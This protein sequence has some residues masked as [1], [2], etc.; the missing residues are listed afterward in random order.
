MNIIKNFRRSSSILVIHLS[1]IKSLFPAEINDITN[2]DSILY[3]LA[4]ITVTAT[5]FPIKQQNV[6]FALTPID[7]ISLQTAR[8]QL[9]LKETLASVPGLLALNENNFSQDLR[10]SIRGFGARASFGIRGI[11]VLIDG[12]PE[13]TPDGQTQ[14]DNLNLGVIDR[15]EVVR[16]PTSALYGNA[17]GGVINIS[18]QKP[19][20]SLLLNTKLTGGSYDFRNIQLK[21][22]QDFGR[23]NILLSAVHS[24]INGYRAHSA[25]KTYIING[26]LQVKPD[27]IS[28]LTL[29]LSWEDSPHADDPG[30]LTREQMTEDPT[31]ASSNNLKFN[32]GEEVNQGKVGLFYKRMF[33]PQHEIQANAYFTDRNF[34]NRLPFEQGG[35]VNLGRDY[36]GVNF[37]YLHTSNIL[38]YSSQFAAGLEFADQR[39]DRKR[40]NN[41]NGNRGDLVLNQEERYTNSAL[42]AQEEIHFTQRWHLNLG[43]RYDIV[44]VRVKNLLFENGIDS[45]ERTLKGLS[46]MIGTLFRMTDNHNLYGNISSGFE[47]P[48][49]IELTN[50][51]EGDSGLN[52]TLNAQQA[53]NYEIGL[54]GILAGKFRYEMALFLIDVYD[55]LL[56]YE[57]AE[58]PGRFYYRNAGRSTHK[59]FELGINGYLTTGLTFALSY[60]LSRFHFVDY[61]LAENNFSDN[62]IPG[63]PEHMWYTEFFYLS[64]SG[65]YSRLEIQGRSNMYVNDAN[66]AIDD[67]YSTV[68]IQAGYRIRFN[69]WYI[70]PFFGI[71]NIF[72]VSYSDNVRINAFGE[73]YYEPAPEFNIFVGLNIHIGE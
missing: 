11:K 42:F 71:N 58:S 51:P 40:F 41:I 34:S 1:I 69:R 22:G 63:I 8:R 48:A 33:N 28:E 13:T 59:G 19:P 15:I 17:S 30:A 43:L 18:S 68:N 67:G 39:D 20:K 16:G 61:Q 72:D 52:Q 70:E 60:T 27:S 14:L 3:E 29:R 36:G 23:T 32:A 21:A 2:P 7:K 9:S 65:I 54:K 46:G 66:S 57:L 37:I 6:V 24:R 10:L 25:M 45:G 62:T 5:R 26:I 50:S 47:T 53:I 49:L 31:Q 38:G 64:S 44:N 56:P 55:E 73:R 12:I 4:P 35:I